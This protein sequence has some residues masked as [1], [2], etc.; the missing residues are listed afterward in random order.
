MKNLKVNTCVFLTLLL[1]ICGLVNAD[2]QTKEGFFEFR[3]LA[4]LGFELDRAF[5]GREGKSLLVIG[6]IK[7]Q[8]AGNAVFMLSAGSQE[9]KELTQL[10]SHIYG[11][12]AVSNSDGMICIGGYKDG[13]LSR[14][15]ISYSVKD[16]MLQA[17]Q[18]PQLPVE[19]PNVKAALVSNRIYIIGSEA[20]FSLDL[21]ASDSKWQKLDSWQPI[22]GEVVSVAAVS[23]RLFVFTQNGGF[24]VLR[25]SANNVFEQIGETNYDLSGMISAPCGLA[26]VIFLSKSGESNEILAYH[27]VTNRWVVIGKLPRK[28]MLIGIVFDDVALEI[29]GADASVKVKAVMPSTKYGLIDHSVVAV[30]MIGMLAVGAYLAKRE[31]SS[32]D[33][34]RGG[35]RIAWWASGLSMFATGASA[36]SLMAMPGKAFSSDWIYFSTSIYAII[37]ILPLSMYLYMP[38]ARRL[39]VATANEYL[40]RRYNIFLRMAGSVI[41]SFLQIFGRMAALMILP[42]IAISSIAGI[43]IENSII[44]MGVITTCYVFLGGLE[45]VIWTS[46]LQAIVMLVAVAACFLWAI[47]GLDMS[48]SDGW[49][50]IQAADK[51]HMFDWNISLVEPC[52]LILFL[53]V[54]VGTLGM[55]GDQNYIQRIQCTPNEKETKKAILMSLAVA[56]PLNAVLFGLGT[57]L[58]LYYM[59]KPEM[60]SPAV[61]SDGI[62]PLFAAQNLPIG[63]AGLVIAAILAATMSTLSSALNSVANIG[64]EDFYRRFKKDATDHSCVILGRILTVGLGVFGTVAALFLAKTNLTSIWDLCMVIFG[65]LI[66]AITGIYT[67]GI[68]TKRANSIGAIAGL[69][70]SLAATYYAMNYTHLHFLTYPVVGVVVCYLVG[71]LT[72]IIIPLKPKDITGL[73]VYTLQKKTE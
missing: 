29:I 72:S 67:L 42:A 62:F 63:L 53:N 16:G 1:F 43:P 24:K 47:A 50:T 55:I 46:V 32:Q 44:I 61:K 9:W 12:A 34:F 71:Y 37:T 20:A 22:R 48:F 6:G 60:L 15:V 30:F 33:Y 65:V 3:E 26:H 31:K 19:I 39:E 54:L 73:T 56:V 23:G 28:V 5:V 58:F 11:G 57:V 27:T 59:E 2:A 36:V 8:V 4:P 21:L 40:E 14:E 51:L 13:S 68:F 52:V 41:W 18:M 66:G 64:V 25:L 49:S 10:Q 70:A 17:K 45:S 38:I 7:S 35:K 69:T